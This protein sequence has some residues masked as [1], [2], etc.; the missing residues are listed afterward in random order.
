VRLRDGVTADPRICGGKPVIEG[1]RVAVS[2]VVGS[3]AAGMTTEEV[4]KE[5]RLTRQQVQ[6]ALAYAAE[7]VEEEGVVP[8]P[9]R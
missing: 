1:T 5:Y 9:S 7:A 6:A 8:L 2:I 3:L 4:C